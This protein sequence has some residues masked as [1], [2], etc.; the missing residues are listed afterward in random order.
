MK[1]YKG[2]TLKKTYLL[3]SVRKECQIGKEVTVHL[4]FHQ[5][6]AKATSA[7]NS[8]SNHLGILILC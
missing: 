1:Q 6:N 3:K 2:K 4:N 5:T 7:I 8:S